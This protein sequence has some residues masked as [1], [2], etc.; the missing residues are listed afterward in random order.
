MIEKRGAPQNVVE[1][2]SVRLMWAVRPLC[3]LRV[4]LAVSSAA[5]QLSEG[6]LSLGASLEW[7]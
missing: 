7:N 1:L 5:M 2:M 6:L 4:L 3:W